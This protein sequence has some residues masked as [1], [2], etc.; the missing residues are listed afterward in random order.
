MTDTTST[1]PKCAA[2]QQCSVPDL[3]L[4][5]EMKHYCGICKR[6]MHGCCGIIHDETSITYRNRCFDCSSGTCATTP[7]L[8]RNTTVSVKL[9]FQPRTCS[10]GNA[11][12]TSAIWAFFEHFDPAYHPDKKHFRICM[13]CRGKNKDK[14]LF[15]G[16]KGCLT[17]L[18][19]HLMTHPKEWAHYLSERASC[20]ASAMEKNKNT[21]GPMQTSLKQHFTSPS[22]H[23]EA[24]ENNYLRWLV[25]ECHALDTGE[26]NDFKTMII[27]LNSKA[28]V[29]TRRTVKKILHVKKIQAETTIK[30][31]LVG[32]FFSLTL[33]HWTSAANENYAAL[34]LH[35]IHDFQ[36][37][38]MVLSCVKHDNGSTAAEMDEQLVADLATWGLQP[39]HFV[40]LVTDT[41]SNMNCLGRLLE[42]RYTR[43]A[44]H[45]C[46]DHN[47]QLTA[48]KAFTG[49]IENYD[50]EVAQDRDG[51]ESTF[52][53]LK[54]AR[55]L[56]SHIRHS[57]ASKEKLDAA[58][59]RV[60]NTDPTLVVIQDVKTRW[61]STYM[62]LE[63]LCKLKAAIQD[64]FYHEFRYRRQCNKTTT[65]EKYELTEGDFSCLEDVVHV[66]LPFKVAQEALEGDKY[67]TLS[68]LPLLVHQIR[69][70]LIRFQGAICEGTQPQ[71]KFLVD[72][73]EEDFM[74]RW[75]AHNRYRFQVS[76]GD[77]G[78]QCGIPRYAFWAAFLDPRTKNK[79]AKILD[80]NDLV[81]L[82]AD[83]TAE[84]LY[85]NEASATQ[86]TE[87]SSSKREKK[88]A[89]HGRQQKRVKLS[90][91][92]LL[93]DLSSDDEH[94]AQ[95]GDRLK[96]QVAEQ[97][98]RYKREKGLPL[99]DDDGAYNCPLIW[100]KEN[101]GHY[102]FIWMLAERILNIPA[103]SA[104]SERVFSAAANIINIKRARLTPENANILLFLK[105]NEEY[106][107]WTN[108]KADGT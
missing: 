92:S 47:L 79:A 105:E 68:L 1:L 69:E 66:L 95:P 24:F 10:K 21:F 100:W 55:D 3:P 34:T 99:K 33:D 94:S 18:E 46:A 39:S 60:N 91:E 37:K 59:R 14:Q 88:G 98:E 40:A 58:Q 54:R 73:M 62:M 82:W 96:R 64:M 15:V 101:C 48:V 77:R 51:I 108:E 28:T 12:K 43:T 70:A 52:S 63:R 30:D 20:T 72:K 56:V 9:E 27:G 8:P 97:L 93:E 89:V 103:T 67:V 38:R 81:Q 76:R 16:K 74:V 36:L 61:W 5:S 32:K 45:Y 80:E 57:P 71:L 17:N 86:D 2:G 44:H 85:M 19:T 25:N 106:V 13:V 7:V 11:K 22:I 53:A 75:G 102:P 6:E 50:G 31:L 78:R 65:L 84:I 23:K 29:P 41:A 90:L 4:P 49:D 35:T 42:T 26:S 87:E 104:P 107:N 83:I